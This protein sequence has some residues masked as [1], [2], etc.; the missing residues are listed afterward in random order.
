MIP[1]SPRVRYWRERRRRGAPL[2]AAACASAAEAE[3]CLPLAPD[4]ILY[5]PAFAPADA[6]GDSGMLAS[7]A[8]LGNANEA[9]AGRLEGLPARCSPCPVAM[10]V[11]GSDPFLLRGP[12]FAAWRAAG[13]EGVA[14]FPTLGLADGFFRAELEAAGLGL[15]AELACL[16][17]AHA[18]GFFTLGFACTPQDAAAFAAAG[19][20]ALIAHLGLTAAYRPMPLAD[21]R[22]AWA[23]FPAATRTGAALGPL[24]L[25]HGDH[26]AGPGDAEAWKGL[27]EEGCDGVFASGGPERVKALRAKIA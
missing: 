2:F 20:D 5:H 15:A 7:L 17:E 27:T 8:P 9:A 13:L 25:L 16:R 21:A 22:A 23:D 18:A 19:C 6:G 4:L 26:L 3:A 24:L 11:C 10:G 12:A 14:N 1:M